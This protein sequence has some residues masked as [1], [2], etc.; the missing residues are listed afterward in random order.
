[1]V[2]ISRSACFYLLLAL[3]S[4]AGSRPVCV[5]AFDLVL[6]LDES[7]SMKTTDPGNARVRAA[8]LFA[9]I[10]RQTDR[11][12]LM[13]FATNVR[14]MSTLGLMGP[15]TARDELE[16]RLRLVRSDGQWT[17]IEQALRLALQNLVLTGDRSK[18]RAVLLMTDGRVDLAPGGRESAESRASDQRIRG[19]LVSDFIQ[20]NIPIY[21]VAFSRGADR[22]LLNYL[23]EATQGLCVQ[24]DSDRELERLFLRLFEEIAQPQTVPVREGKVLLDAAVRE[25]TFLVTHGRAGTRVTVTDPDAREHGRESAVEGVSWYAGAT[26]D[27]VTVSEPK[28]GTWSI[29][30]GSASQNSRVLVLTDLELQV[31]DLPAF[32]APGETL[33]VQAFL[34]SEGERVAEPDLLKNLVVTGRLTGR[35]SET[36]PLRDDGT[37]PDEAP[38]DGFYGGRVSPTSESGFYDVEI[39]AAAPT[40][41]RR[42]LRKVCV[43]NR[44]FSVDVEKDSIATGELAALK[45]RVS[46]L[47]AIE[48][49]GAHLGFE[50]VVQRPDQTRKSLTV[51]PVTPSLYSVAFTDTAQPGE[52]RVTVM[53]RMTSADGAAQE[54]TVGPL[55]IHVAQV[56]VPATVEN[57]ATPPPV[58]VP[59]PMVVEPAEKP[60]APRSSIP[61]EFWVVVGVLLASVGVLV[62]LL[63]RRRPDR[64]PIQSMERLR[65][66]ALE[67]REES[68]EMEEAGEGAS[69]LSAGGASAVRG[70]MGGAAEV[71]SVAR[72]RKVPPPPTGVEIIP[73]PEVKTPLPEESAAEELLVA[74]EPP[75]LP[76]GGE[77]MSQEESDLLAEIL[78]ESADLETK[79]GLPEIPVAKPLTP[80]PAALP[81]AAPVL[82]EAQ[83][84]LLADIMEDVAPDM[85]EETKAQKLP[86]LTDEESDLL[87]DIM[88]EIGDLMQGGTAPSTVPGTPAPPPASVP[89]VPASLSEEESVLLADIV[90]DL[91]AMQSPPPP[92]AFPQMEAAPQPQERAAGGLS[93]AEN[94]LLADIL[95]T[96][97][98]PEKSLETTPKIPDEK[99]KR[100]DQE[101]IDDILRD[102]EGL[103]D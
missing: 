27:I 33:E 32:L 40:F 7:G 71:E 36:F 9:R 97:D 55:A 15:G 3:V 101:I 80:P 52:Y 73:E 66:R 77:E 94:D 88:G 53:G 16:A 25:A 59:T 23:S 14:E 37:K 69:A 76:M 31:Q 13:G 67:I 47:E 21:S 56:S 45:V 60:L 58:P 11:V 63:L 50:A 17:D 100:S 41:E 6:L 57:V 19:A 87:A 26:Y 93:D 24:G 83:S 34:Q 98:F 8:E 84:S 38:G 18:P 102:I 95:G 29:E 46:D 89:S 75:D 4:L 64:E 5:S 79:V 42:I 43:L 22:A 103:V 85:V 54:V 10:C 81:D 68:G 30:P 44:W 91:E 20:E 99:D 12:A 51:D 90:G 70:S 28:P 65:R 92:A 39:I 86:A 78:G 61:W 74:A 48:K 49:A 72:R 62:V 1:M 96:D 35:E 2:R 82:D